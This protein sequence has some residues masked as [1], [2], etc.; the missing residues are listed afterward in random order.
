MAK[1]LFVGGL[2]YSTTDAQLNEYF[3]Q[4]GKVES[5]NIIT[6]K[7]TGQSK[8]FGFVEMSTE[9]EA[10]KAIDTLNDQD[11]GGRKL[12]VQEAKPMEERAPRRSF[13]N[14]RDSHG[15]GGQR[16]GQRGGRW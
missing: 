4:A 9:E 3:S 1:R 6:D 5:C 2:P 15:G 11:F 12:L 13:G 10:K 14:D 8:G 7:F 16:G